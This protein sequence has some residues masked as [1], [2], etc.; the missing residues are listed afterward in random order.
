M[1]LGGL[2][3]EDGFDAHCV[4]CGAGY[5]FEVGV[6]GDTCPNCGGSQTQT[7][8]DKAAQATS[9]ARMARE[10]TNGT[11]LKEKLLCDIDCWD[12]MTDMLVPSPGAAALLKAIADFKKAVQTAR[13]NLRQP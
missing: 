6:G 8:A 1:S 13:I 10:W 4:N 11:T 3:D 7:P 2:D 5:Y 12:F 9:N